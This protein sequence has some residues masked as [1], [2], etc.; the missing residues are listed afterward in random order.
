MMFIDLYS[1]CSVLGCKKSSL[2]IINDCVGYLP[3]WHEF[4]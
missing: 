2:T 1:I 3:D 4:Y